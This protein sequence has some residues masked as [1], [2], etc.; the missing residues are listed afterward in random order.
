MNTQP[1][2]TELLNQYECCV[3]IPTYNNGKTLSRVINGVLTYTASI[4]VVNDGCTDDTSEIL[5]GFSDLQIIHLAKNKGKGNALHVGLK[6]AEELGFDYAIT[7]DSDG[8]HYPDDIPLFINVLNNAENKNLVL[9]GGRNLNAD[10]MPKKN[11]F[12]NKFSNFWYWAET[13]EKL[14]DTQSGFRLYPVKKVNALR[15]FTTKYEFEIEV[16]VKASWA[17]IEVKN[18]PIRVL[19][20]PNERVS[21]FRP[22][23]DFFRISLL[24]TWLVLVALFYIKPYNL[25]RKIKKKGLKKFFIEDFLGSKD[26]NLKKTLSITLGTFI[27]ISPFWGFQTFLSIFLAQ[28]FKLNKTISFAFSNVSIPPLIPFII[29]GSFKTGGFLLNKKFTLH[30]DN[31]SSNFDVKAHTEHLWQYVV[32]SFALATI[33]SVLFG[34]IG[35]GALIVFNKEK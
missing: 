2:I 6:K 27:G 10:G 9:I 31:I 24:N 34:A 17:G 25:F 18:I 35:Y 13:G 14:F 12:A 32:G 1:N 20:D 8:Q 19:Y 7:I 16:I 5:Q 21:H 30:L 11:T 26:S 22:F 23:K 33:C 15:L 29:Y 4:I 28:V 3:I